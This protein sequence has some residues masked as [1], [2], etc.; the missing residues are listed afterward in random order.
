LTCFIVENV[1]S[2]HVYVFPNLER[3]FSA[4]SFSLG[5]LFMLVNFQKLFPVSNAVSIAAYIFNK[6][7]YACSVVIKI[8]YCSGGQLIWLEGYFAKV[9]F[10]W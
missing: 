5:N 2:L 3:I 9:G 8:T 1:R 7:C 6:R 4:K 10:C